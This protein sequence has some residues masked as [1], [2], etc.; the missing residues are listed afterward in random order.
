MC[1]SYL[2]KFHHRRKNLLFK[3]KHRFAWK[4]QSQQALSFLDS[5]G[6]ELSNQPT[7]QDVLN[8]MDINNSTYLGVREEMRP[9]HSL[10]KN[11]HVSEKFERSI[12]TCRSQRGKKYSVWGEKFYEI[13]SYFDVFGC[14][15]L[16]HYWLEINGWGK[17]INVIILS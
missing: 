15:H 9:T 7:T 8:C 17:K 6:E 11:L 14:F 1:N 5:Q 4:Y 2:Y 10:S 3:E 13:S 12:R 16:I